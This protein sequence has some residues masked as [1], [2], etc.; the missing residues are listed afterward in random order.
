MMANSNSQKEH[1]TMALKPIRADRVTG[2][3]DPKGPKDT[4]EPGPTDHETPRLSLRPSDI[5]PRLVYLIVIWLWKQTWNRPRS[6]GGL[7][8]H[9]SQCFNKNIK[10]RG[11]IWSKVI[12][13][14][15]NFRWTHNKYRTRENKDTHREKLRKIAN[16][17]QAETSDLKSHWQLW[18]KPPRPAQMVIFNS[19]KIPRGAR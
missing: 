11:K 19:L 10:I 16:R 15:K 5:K 1:S 4:E 9:H 13:L 6:R 8:T 12:S 2:V 3:I 7:R 18:P 17:K 14:N